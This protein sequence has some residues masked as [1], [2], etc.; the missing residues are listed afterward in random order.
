[1]KRAQKAANAKAK[2]TT[3]KKAVEVTPVKK[4]KVRD[5]R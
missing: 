3:V 5:S 4:A 2:K 1:M